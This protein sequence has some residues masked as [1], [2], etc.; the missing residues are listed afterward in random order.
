MP[1]GS[2]VLVAIEAGRITRVLADGTK[3]TVA[4][5]GG[6]PNGLAICP[7]GT[8]IA[9][10]NGGLIY[11]DRG[12]L[13][14]PGG[15]PEDYSGGRIEGFYLANGAVEVSIKAAI[16][17]DRC[18]GRTTSCSTRTAVSVLPIMARPAR[19]RATLPASSTPRPM[20]RSWKK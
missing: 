18:A 2:I 14:V 4:D 12:A 20:V 3:Q 7:N 13:L 6:G 15:Q 17:A 10:T 8:C 5:P 9:K 1:D 16:S 19:A 11:H